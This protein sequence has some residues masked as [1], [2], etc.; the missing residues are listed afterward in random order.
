MAKRGP[1]CTICEHERRH[2]IEIGLVY[3]VPLRVLARRFGVSA[4]ALH[5]HKQNHLSPQVAA[6]ILAAQKPSAI[7]LE[8]LQ[9]SESEGLLA[10]LV[11]QR[12]RLQTHSELATDLGDVRSPSPASEQSPRTLNSLANCWGS[13]CIAMRFDRLHFSSVPITWPYVQPL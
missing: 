7:D 2:Q 10:Q 1:A 11:A 8:A 5:R 13:W 3:Q 6:A 12:A 4:D 9:A